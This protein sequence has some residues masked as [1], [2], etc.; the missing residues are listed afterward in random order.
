MTFTYTYILSRV[1]VLCV[2]AFSF[3]IP[4]YFSRDG[5]PVWF[6]SLSGSTPAIPDVFSVFLMM[7]VYAAMTADARPLQ[8]VRD[9]A[10]QQYD[11][12]LPMANR[13]SSILDEGA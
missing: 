7:C 10:L 1:R 12:S 6:G 3:C 11:T 5:L 13:S 9:A 4:G 8:T 2:S